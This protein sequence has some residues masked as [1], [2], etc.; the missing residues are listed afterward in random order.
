[1]LF[2]TATTMTAGTQMVT[3]R[4]PDMIQKG[5]VFRGWLN[6]ALALFVMVSVGSLL[7]LAVSRWVGVLTGMVSRP[8][9]VNGVQ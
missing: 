6:I 7:L 8:R 2:V 4:F 5:E 1:M 9:E 3:G